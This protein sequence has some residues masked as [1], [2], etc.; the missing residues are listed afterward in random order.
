MIKSELVKTMIEAHPDLG[1][2]NISKII[3]IIF[4]GLS[5]A[6]KDGRRIEIRGFGSFSVRQRPESASRNPRNNIAITL[7]ERSIIY[8]R[9]GKEFYER[10]NNQPE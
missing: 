10:V 1:A 6:L 3:D 5:Q 4:N 9:I 8:F 7:G 2:N